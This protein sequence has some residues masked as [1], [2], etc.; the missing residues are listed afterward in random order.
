MTSMSSISFMHFTMKLYSTSN[1][2]GSGSLVEPLHIPL[3]TNIQ[4]CIHKH[5]EERQ[6]SSL[7][8]LPGIKTILI[9]REKQGHA[10]KTVG[11]GP[12]FTYRANTFSHVIVF[13]CL[14]YHQDLLTL[15]YGE[16]KLAMHTSPASANSRATSAMRRMFSSR[17]SGLKPRF[18]FN[19]W[20]MLSP[21]KV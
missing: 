16:M 2:S 19:P 1:L 11:R 18:L 8:D 10:V 4:G 14:F 20:R 7:V 15:L 21:S 6:P 17:S 9:L 5:L 13:V 3:L 12:F